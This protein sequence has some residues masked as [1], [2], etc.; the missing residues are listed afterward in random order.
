MGIVK[1][2]TVVVGAR[3]TIAGTIF[4][5]NKAG[6]YARGWARGSNPSTT[7]QGVARASVATFAALWRTLD[8]SVQSGWDL[9]AADPAQARSNALGETYYMSGY[10]AFVSI[11]LC[12]AA[13]GRSYSSAVPTLAKPAAPVMEGI[14][15]SAGSSDDTISWYVGQFSPTY[16]LVVEVCLASGPGTTVPVGPWKTIG[17]WQVPTGTS[18]VITSEMA[19]RFGVQRAGMQAFARAY[20]QTVEGYRSGA[21]T[22]TSAVIG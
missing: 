6:P 5:A 1:F 17:G 10:Q 18:K 19:A 3:G 14:V 7:L 11:N 9:W 2:G 20:R 13:V 15:V 16:D 12:L 21:Y 8:L 22:I 4:S